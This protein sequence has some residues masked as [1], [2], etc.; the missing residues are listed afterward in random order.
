MIPGED[1]IAVVS[2]D[3]RW[4]PNVS[5]EICGLAESHLRGITTEASGGV[6]DAPA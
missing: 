5:N 3:G 4:K 2:F 6:R 1:I